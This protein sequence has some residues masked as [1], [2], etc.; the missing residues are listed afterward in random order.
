MKPALIYEFRGHLLD[1]GRRRLQRGGNDI[2]IRPKSLALLVYLIEN[3]GRVIDKEELIGAIWPNSI[4]SDD[5]LSQCLKDV[6]AALGVEAEGLIKTVP[7]RGYIVDEG[8][9]RCRS[10]LPPPQSEKPSIAILPFRPLASDR[11]HNWFAEGLTEDIATALTRSR[12]LMVVSR[13]AR[14]PE[15]KVSRSVAEVAGSFRVRYVVDGSIRLVGN[16]LRVSSQ[17]IDAHSGSI[18]W[19]DRFDRYVNDVFAIQDEITDAIV[20]HLEIKL[21][22]QERRS[23]QLSRTDNMEAYTYYRHGWQLAR[24]WTKAY[25]MVA[26]RMFTQAAELDPIFARAHS[27]IALCDCYLLEWFASNETPGSILAMAEKALAL[28]ANLAEA[29]VARALAFQKSGRIDDARTAY[30]EA[31][32]IDPTCFEARLFAGF[33]AWTQGQRDVAMAQFVEAAQLRREDYLGPYFVLAAI[34]KADP[35]KLKWAQLALEL[36]EHA[37]VLQPDNPAPLSRGAVALY[38]LGKF[39][40]AVSWIKRALILDPD[41]P[42]TNYNAAAVYS[43]IGDQ[44]TALRFLEAYVQRSSEDMVDLVRND[45]DLAGIRSYPGYN[46]LLARS[47]GLISST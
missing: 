31:L 16:R 33:L 12:Q 3:P 23:I 35:E 26:R 39:Q 1:L 40:E 18:L 11:E 2:M 21:L 4:V 17:L 24:H 32:A 30:A 34:D 44:A 10:E 15:P 14:P 28:D 27:A 8:Q 13:L 41:D 46:E 37:A 47:W 45:D 5:S 43:V 36:A 7:R 29:H 22:P 38:H 20:R 25:L 42:I 6:R 19:A 9:I